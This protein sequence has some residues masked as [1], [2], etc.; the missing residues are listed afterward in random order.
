MNRGGRSFAKCPKGG[1]KKSEKRKAF[2]DI[3]KY[4]APEEWAML[5]Y[6]QKTAYVYMKKNYD[7][8]THLGNR[9]PWIHTSIPRSLYMLWLLL[10]LQQVS[11]A[12]LLCRG[13]IPRQ[14]LGILLFYIHLIPK[15]PAK[16]ENDPKGVPG[17]RGSEWAQRQLCP[18]GK[19]STTGKKKK[20]TV[21]LLPQLGLQGDKNVWTHQLWERKNLVAYDEIIGY[22]ENDPII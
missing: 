9:K 14:F 17:T 11:H 20:K 22:D 3:A 6:T 15:K 16:K 21:I 12:F 4:F 19:A 5:G 1:A 8:M 7:T 2:K 10:R 18:T 13:E